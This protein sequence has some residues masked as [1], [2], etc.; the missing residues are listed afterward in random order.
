MSN[1]NHKEKLDPALVRP[2]RADVSVEFRNASKDQA[3]RL[4]KIFYPLDGK[5]GIKYARRR[6]VGLAA[7]NAE[8]EKEPVKISQDTIESLAKKFR[9][10][11]PERAFS[12][13][14]IQGEFALI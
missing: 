1:S 4:F 2:G 5:F 7:L 11:I 3:K 9:D 6:E 13:A 10:L 14:D 8:E 12:T